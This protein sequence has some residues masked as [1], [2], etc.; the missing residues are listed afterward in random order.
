[1]DLTPYTRPR[2]FQFPR[3]VATK[4][5]KTLAKHYNQEYPKQVW[6]LVAAFLFLVGVTHYGSVARRKLF[7]GKE[8]ADVGADGRVVRHTASLRRLPLTIANAYRVAAFRT[9]L[10]LGPFNLNLAEVALTIAYI[11]ALFVWSFINS[12]YRGV[13]PT[14][15]LTILLATALDG[16]KFERAYYL[17][18]SANIACGQL[19]LVTA[20]GTK[21]NIVGCKFCFSS[22]LKR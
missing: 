5:D 22:R 18:R 15:G 14:H 17:N 21:N 1:M 6:W 16:T 11:V 2:P 20:L 3:M 7:P 12:T 13:P 19:P 9:T 10:V 4:A 8:P